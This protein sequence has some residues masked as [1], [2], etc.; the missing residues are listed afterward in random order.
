MIG[1]LR[2]LLPGRAPAPKVVAER[3]VLQLAGQSVEYELR[4]S[5]RR[6]LGL[7]VDAGRVL[8]SV[9]LRVPQAEVDAFLAQHLDWLRR[10]LAEQ[11]SLPVFAAVDGARFP[12]LGQSCRLKVEPGRVRAAWSTDDQGEVLSVG[13]ADPA[14]AVV[15]ALKRRA[16]TD[17]SARLVEHCARFGVA[18][19]QLRLTSARTRWGSCS[20]RSG[21]R[22]HWRLMH[23]EPVLIDYVVAHEVAHLAEMNHSPRFWELVETLHPQWQASRS[24]LRAVGA[25]LPLIQP[26]VG[27]MPHA[28][29]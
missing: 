14:S 22:L 9:P 4:R 12:V 15:R 11:G 24:R 28:E 8:V 2:R 19:P 21:I 29:D 27:G 16:L 17:F 18:V 6:T 3:R 26:G 1:L 5:V 13:E 25:T 7:R 23:L 10:R 20:S